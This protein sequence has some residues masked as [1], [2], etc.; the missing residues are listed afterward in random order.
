[1]QHF[2]EH[3][4]W[5]S[6][7]LLCLQCP[8]LTGSINIWRWVSKWW[9]K[10]RWLDGITDSMDTRLSKL[11]ERVKDREACPWGHRVRHDWATE[12]QHKVRVKDRSSS[13]LIQKNVKSNR[14]ILDPLCSQQ[15]QGLHFVLTIPTIRTILALQLPSPDA[16]FSAHSGDFLP[17]SAKKE[18]VGHIHEMRSPA[19]NKNESLTTRTY[20]RAQG[21]LLNV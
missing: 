12:Q 3:R 8:T 2:W 5:L 17:C 16:Q 21:T 18:N 1:M 9:Q 4:S 14:E 19:A 20:G 13:N 7:S 6:Y 15:L 10:M 11:W